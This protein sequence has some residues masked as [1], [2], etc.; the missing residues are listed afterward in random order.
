M[1]EK[2]LGRL[3]LCT[4][5]ETDASGM[6]YEW[7]TLIP[8]PAFFSNR[9]DGLKNLNRNENRSL[10]G[11]KRKAGNSARARSQQFDFEPPFV[12]ASQ[13]TQYLVT[14]HGTPILICQAPPHPGERPEPT[15]ATYVGWQEK[16]DIYARYYLQEF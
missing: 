2:D 8:Y 3:R 15:S 9:G 13:F 5:H 12:C 11:F 16:A 1:L 10:I 14:K 7:K 6:R 4:F